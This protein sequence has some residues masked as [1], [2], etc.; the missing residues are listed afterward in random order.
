MENHKVFEGKIKI[1]Q[2]LDIDI[3][4]S[5]LFLA[6]ILGLAIFI[7]QNQVQEFCGQATQTIQDAL[8][9]CGPYLVEA[10]N[11]TLVFLHKLQELSGQMTQTIKDAL[12]MLGPYLEEATDKI[13]A[14]LTALLAE[15]EPEPGF[16]RC[17][18]S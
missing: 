10:K 11:K 15:R 16:Q 18:L 3:E 8:E 14:F 6:V 4:V 17:Y 9:F 1:P 12:E 13:L 2:L 5:Y 7:Y